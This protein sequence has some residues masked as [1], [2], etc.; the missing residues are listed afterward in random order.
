LTRQLIL[1]PVAI[2]DLDA[3]YRHSTERWGMEQART[4][5]Q[6]L[7]RILRLLADHPEIARLRAEFSPPVYLHPF[8]SHLVVFRYYE[9]TLDVI[10]IVHARSNWQGLL[11]D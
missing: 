10:R 3:I 9:M 2:A 6:S 1:T 4:Y 5:L 7:D 8:R 11:N